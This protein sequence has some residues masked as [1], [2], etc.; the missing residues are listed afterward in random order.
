MTDLS[1]KFS[2]ITTITER[3]MYSLCTGTGRLNLNMVLGLRKIPRYKAIGFWNRYRIIYLPV[4]Q[5]TEKARS[6]HFGSALLTNKFFKSQNGQ[7]ASAQFSFCLKFIFQFFI[8][9]LIISY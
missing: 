3:R 2:V 8:N 9:T 5:E 6:H 1:S 7:R 4:G